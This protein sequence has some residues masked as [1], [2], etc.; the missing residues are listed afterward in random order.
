MPF[1]V[2]HVAAVLPVIGRSGRLPAAALVIGSMAPDVPWFF[3]GGRGAGLT[4]S[5]LGVLTV[6]LVVGLAAV[7]VWWRWLHAPVRDL[8][9]PRIGER[10]PVPRAVTPGL[11]PWA[12]VAVVVGAVTHV[13][14]D[15]FTHAGRWGVDLVP[16]L[17]AEHL[18][19]PGYKWA[20]FASGM[21]GGLVVVLFCARHLSRAVPDRSAL[22]SSDRQ[23]RAAW[24]LVA[25][26]GGLGALVGVLGAA[27][28]LESA[29]F[30]AVTRGGAAAAVG[31]VGVCVWWWTAAVS[32]RPVEVGRR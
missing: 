17:R 13:V 11:L 7:L 22:R 18:G 28:S 21:I 3:T 30:G 14:W 24:A 20:Q 15:G 1:T 29:L 8:A 26:T 16:W 9:P 6:D 31:T 23:R 32:S 2:S 19:L 27:G 25:G 10:L 5:A 4:H 12:A